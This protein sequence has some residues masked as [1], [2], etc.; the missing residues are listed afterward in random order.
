MENR[1][2]TCIGCPIGCNL[3]V[4]IG[5][6]GDITVTGNTCPKGAEYAKNEVTNP[7]R[8]VTS[9][10]QVNNGKTLSV[11]TKEDIPKD[12]IMDCVLALKN[13]VA[14]APVHIGDV[15]LHN[16]AGTG[17]DIVATKNIV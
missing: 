4:T 12:K 15:V 1:E 9:T 11:K 2:L 13:V 7:R 17:I 3:T 14:K 10:V 8:T 5:D 6:N 16:V